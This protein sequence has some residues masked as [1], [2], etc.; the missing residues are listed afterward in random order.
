MN[1]QWCQYTSARRKQYNHDTTVRW[2]LQRRL[3]FTTKQIY[4]ERRPFTA[5]AVPPHAHVGH[6]PSS[7][8]LCS[9]RGGR[10]GYLRRYSESHISI[11]ELDVGIIPIGLPQACHRPCR[12]GMAAVERRC[13]EVGLGS[14]AHTYGRGWDDLRGEV[15]RLG[16]ACCGWDRPRWHGDERVVDGE[17]GPYRRVELLGQCVSERRR[18]LMSGSKES[19]MCLDEFEV[20]PVSVK[21]HLGRIYLSADPWMSRPL[22]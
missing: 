10:R 1:D 14:R 4:Q 5:F 22:R 7:T 18:C 16:N 6:I 9:C 11:E 15:W 17:D 12:L 19:Q 8:I 3:L 13:Q 2:T 21:V 20:C